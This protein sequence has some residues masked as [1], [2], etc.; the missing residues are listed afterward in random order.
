MNKTTEV[1]VNL[2]NDVQD[3][4]ALVRAL[5]GEQRARTAQALWEQVLAIQNQVAAIRAS[6]VR[7]M[8]QA[9]YSLSR[10]GEVL[11]LSVTRVKQIED[12]AVAKGGKD[13]K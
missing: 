11:D 13:P 12:R 5:D 9:G 2:V 10:V 1:P 8:R 7:E 6:G 3:S 4:L